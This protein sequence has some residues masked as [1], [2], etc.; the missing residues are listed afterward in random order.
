M[1]EEFMRKC[2]DPNYELL[3]TANDECKNIVARYSPTL[4]DVKRIKE[5]F[6]Y[7]NKIIDLALKSIGK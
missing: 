5:S 2:K 1:F 7:V 4:E 3:K 6:S